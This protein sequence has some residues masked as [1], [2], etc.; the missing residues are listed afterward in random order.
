[1]KSVNK[2]FCCAN[3]DLNQFLYFITEDTEP[4]RE[5]SKTRLSKTKPTFHHPVLL[6]DW[7][8]LEG[9]QTPFIKHLEPFL[10]SS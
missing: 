10:Q 7:K 5:V 4:R 6:E 9:D 8:L 3:L 2:R 1:M